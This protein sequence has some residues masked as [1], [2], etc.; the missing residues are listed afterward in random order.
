MF[1]LYPNPNNGSMM[2]DYNLKDN[3]NATLQIVDITGKLINTYKLQNN[4]GSLS[5]NE[6]SLINGVYFYRILVG[7][8]I[9]KTDKLVIIK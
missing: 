1:N 7:D 6:Q 2:L 9:I 3:T 5:I 8:K 4:V